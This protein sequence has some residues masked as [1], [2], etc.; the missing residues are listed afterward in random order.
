MS[1][2]Q[3]VE[4]IPTAGAVEL[5][6]VWRL[7]EVDDANLADALRVSRLTMAL[8]HYRASMF[9]PTEYSHLYRYVM[10]ERMVDVQFPDGPHTGLRNDPPRSGPVWIWVLEVVGVSQLQARVS[11]CVDYGWSGRPGV[12]TLP[13]V[14]RA[15]LESHDLVWEAGADGEFRWVVDGI[16]NQDSALG[17]E[18]RDECDAWASHTPDD[19]D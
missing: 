10:T 4:Q 16:W 18:Y 3:A 2:E 6:L 17:P 9:D 11:Y 15:G 12:D 7:P 13:R 8:G 1:Y 5:P 14:S 19:L